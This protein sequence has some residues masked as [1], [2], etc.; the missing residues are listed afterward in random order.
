MGVYMIVY[1][2]VYTIHNY[3]Y[4]TI[5]YYKMDVILLSDH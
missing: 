5:K 2:R 3:N 4:I 1:K